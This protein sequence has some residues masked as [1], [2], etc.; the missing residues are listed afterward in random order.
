MGL[1]FA[2]K[3]AIVLLFAAGVLTAPAAAAAPEQDFE[4]WT[5]LSAT[6]SLQG[7]VLGSIE[8]TARADD[9]GTRRPLTVVRSMLGYQAAKS[10]SL[11]VG[12][13]RQSSSPERRKAVNENRLF[14]Q[15]S[16]NI[17]TVRGAAVASRTRLEQRTVEGRRDTGWRFRQQVR[18][19]APLRKGGPSAVATSEAFF[20]L[21]ST[22]FGS[23]AGFDQ[24]RNSAGLN[25]PLTKEV[26]IESGYL[27]R[28]IFRGAAR[29]RMDHVIPV[30]V[31]LRF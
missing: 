5:T 23:V 16:W 21:N 24:W 17:G 18:L 11:W 4:V 20:A 10:L 19:S 13:V 27:N 1:N 25:F 3:S 8:M 31:A 26:S 12:Y 2:T 6:G 9:R 15:V 14:Q 28:Y 7:T 22:D 30:T 29:D